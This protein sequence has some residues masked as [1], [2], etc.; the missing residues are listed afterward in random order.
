MQR[1]TS[2]WKSTAPALII[3][4]IIWAGS[5]IATNQ[6]MID[7]NNENQRGFQ[8]EMLNVMKDIKHELKIKNR[9]DEEQDKIL[10]NHEGRLIRIETGRN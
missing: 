2:I 1:Y 10:V 8:R 5:Q 9:K 4:A 6:R 3:A 7:V